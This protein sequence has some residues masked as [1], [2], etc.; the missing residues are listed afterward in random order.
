MKE[1]TAFGM[2]NS[3]TL[4]SLANKSFN[5]LKDKNDVRLYTYNDEFM[6]HFVRQSINGDH[7]SALKQYY[8]SNISDKVF[9]IISK[10][11]DIK[12]NVCEILERC[13]EYTKKT[14]KK[15]ENEYDSK[16]IDYR[17]NDEEERTE[18]FNK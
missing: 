10:E 4:P 11:L 5:N 2:K 12:G 6:R 1:L 3:S 9:N 15:R 7:C 13:F 18:H 8:K 16:F 17:D 14:F